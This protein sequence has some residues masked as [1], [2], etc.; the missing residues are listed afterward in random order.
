MATTI[1]KELLCKDANLTQGVYPYTALDCVFDESGN[2]LESLVG[3]TLDVL[4][5]N[6]SPSDTSGFTGDDYDFDIS[7]KNY[8]VFVVDFKSR[9]NYANG[10]TLIIT[11]K[12]KSN[13]VLI[14]TQNKLAQRGITITD[15]GMT[16]GD[17][18]Y[19]NTYGASSDTSNIYLIPTVVYGVKNLFNNSLTNLDAI[20]PIGSIYMS[21]NNVNPTLLFGGTWEAIENRFL[22]GA[23]SSYTAGATGGAA[24]VSLTQ[25]NMPNHYHNV[26]TTN[27]TGTLANPGKQL[28]GNSSNY[29]AVN[30]GTGYT[31]VQTDAIGA[32]TAHNNMPPYLVVYM[33]KRTA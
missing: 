18:A 28:R 32:G 26:T 24:T 2:S 6:P 8:R 23:G 5:T 1:T 9:Y 30:G 13:N 19:F 16:V 10:P 29:Y 11:V 27:A 21:V 4:W 33:W 17:C 14:V 7:P 25:N 15:T 3:S 12:N 20:Y 22:L 31:V